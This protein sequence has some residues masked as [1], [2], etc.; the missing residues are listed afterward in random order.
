ME[1]R[2][3][4]GNCV[5][6]S[7]KKSS[8]LIDDIAHLGAK[9]VATDKDIL[10]IT[11]PRYSSKN[12]KVHFIIDGPGEFE[13][14]EVS[15][16]GISTRSHIDEEKT[17]N[18]TMYRVIMDDVRVGIIG[19]VHPDLS[20]DT[21]EELGTLDVLCIPIGGNGYT[22]DGIGAQKIIKK[23]EPKVIIPTH[24]DEK[25]LNYEVPQQDLETALK[26]LAIEPSETLEVY[27][28]KNAEIGDS[29]KLIVLEHK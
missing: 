13:V 2:F 19:H 22:L 6:L 17:S 5:R 20:D 9:S 26:A 23:I 29:N 12:E 21:L 14:S 18:A 7:T 28:I 25:G 27:K 4:G 11:D 8:V 10:L 24:Y 3:Y 15:I 16:A 1:I